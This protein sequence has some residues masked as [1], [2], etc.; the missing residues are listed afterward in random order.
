MIPQLKA[1]LFD[2]DSQTITKDSLAKYVSINDVSFK[3]NGKKKTLDDNICRQMVDYIGTRLGKLEKNQVVF[4]DSDEEIEDIDAY[5]LD[6]R[7]KGMQTEYEKQLESFKIHD[8][9]DEDDSEENKGFEVN[10][11]LFQQFMMEETRF[12]FSEISRLEEN[13]AMY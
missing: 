11:E 2:K 5:L 3:K 10:E 4:D 12:H 6:K 7:R 8:D 13:T 1:Y 9:D